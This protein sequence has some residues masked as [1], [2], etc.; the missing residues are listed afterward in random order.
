VY[1][2][3]LVYEDCGDR[4]DEY[5][6][7]S[8]EKDLRITTHGRAA[9]VQPL[10]APA[11][12]TAYR[13]QHQLDL[14]A[15]LATDGEHSRR[16]TDTVACTIETELRLASGVP[17]LRVS[18]R[19]A[20]HAE[21]HRIRVLV[22]T[23]I[24][25]TTHLAHGQ[26]DVIRRDNEPWSGWENPSHCRKHD[27]FVAL[28]DSRGGVA[29]ANRGLPE[30][31]I[32]EGG[33]IALTLLRCVGEL[34][35]WGVFPTPGAQCIGE[36]EFQFAIFP[37]GGSWTDSCAY[38]DCLAFTAP[39]RA[40]HSTVHD[41]SVDDAAAWF[42]VDGDGLV[43]SALKRGEHDDSVVLR[44]YNVTEAEVPLTVT[45]VFPIRQAVRTNLDEKEQSRLAVIGDRV[46][47]DVVGPKQIRTYAMVPDGPME[48]RGG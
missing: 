43:V 26:F 33:T 19:I 10:A 5:R 15:G 13:I 30:Y 18:T 20:N 41:G 1:S 42:R 8:P 14:P 27:A 11:G 37:F 21:N 2:G 12:E 29:V 25:S 31:E 36:Y 16:S 22:P 7:L 3:L 9:T 34:G 45:A 17:G 28:E 46:F 40:F 48:S 4:G 47:Q 39:M 23:G 6:F 44:L 38:R 35:D 24:E 32:V